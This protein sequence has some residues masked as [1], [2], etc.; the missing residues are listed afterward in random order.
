MTEKTNNSCSTFAVV[1]DNASQ[2]EPAYASIDRPPD[3]VPLC[4][5]L[6]KSGKKYDNQENINQTS[7]NTYAELNNPKNTANQNNY[8]GNREAVQETIKGGKVPQEHEEVFP[9]DQSSACVYATVD[10][11]SKSSVEVM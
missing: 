1:N 2:S 9:E 5:A 8:H 3:S 10:K 7:D 6:D 4:A 11:S